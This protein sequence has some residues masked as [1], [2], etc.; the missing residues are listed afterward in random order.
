MTEFSISELKVDCCISKPNQFLFKEH[1]KGHLCLRHDGWLLLKL[2]YPYVLADC[3]DPLHPVA[4]SSPFGLIWLVQ[5]FLG[6]VL[7]GFSLRKIFF[8]VWSFA[9]PKKSTVLPPNTP[10]KHPCF[11]IYFLEGSKGPTEERHHGWPA[12]HESLG[13]S[14][15]ITFFPPSFH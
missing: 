11:S 5:V 2:S 9:L 8:L 6:F 10:A 3:S 15:P 14:E 7:G 12:D 13:N 4:W 1:L